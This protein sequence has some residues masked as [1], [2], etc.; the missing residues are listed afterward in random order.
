MKR[1]GQHTEL[2]SEHRIA[3]IQRR[4]SILIAEHNNLPEV[5]TP[6]NINEEAQIIRPRMQQ[7]I[8]AAFEAFVQ[9]NMHLVVADDQMQQHTFQW[10]LKNFPPERGGFDEMIQRM[11]NGKDINAAPAGSRLDDGRASVGW[12]IWA[13]S[14]DLDED[15]QLT[16]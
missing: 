2:P 7:Y 9:T 6:Q 3:D 1:P 4:G 11:R 12:I 13:M 8:Y 16:K 5:E 14:D 10:I 15:G